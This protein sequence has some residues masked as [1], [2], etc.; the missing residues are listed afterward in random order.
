ME[1]PQ[2]AVVAAERAVNLTPDPREGWLSLLAHAYYLAKDPARMASTL[3]RLV[4]RVPTRKSYWMLLSAAY[5]E[6]GRDEE[7]R[8]LVQ[9]AH[10]QGLLDQDREVRAL[11]RLLLASGLPYDAAIALEKGMADGV[12]PGQAD[13]YE[14]LTNCFLQAREGERALG[15]LAR[16]AELAE[17][18]Q[19][20]MLLGKVHLQRER[21]EEALAALNQGLGKATSDQ[22]GRVYLLIGVAQLGAKRLDEAERAFLS[23]RADERTDRYL[24]FVAQERERRR[25]LGLERH[26][27]RRRGTSR[28]R[29]EPPSGG[30]AALAA[31]DARAQ[32]AAIG[33]GEEPGEQHGSQDEAPVGRVEG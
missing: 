25:E 1:R 24:R 28:S 26:A 29:D 6:L 18:A 21:F 22:R 31:V 7:A 16:G 14:L 33:V 9:L 19:L 11:A 10:R 8:S 2:D 12:V 30:P 17:G 13:S 4:E 20:H 32:P 5:L 27:W 15:P 23:A 3:E